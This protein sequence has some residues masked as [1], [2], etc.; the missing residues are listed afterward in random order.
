MT[1]KAT[2]SRLI[3]TVYSIVSPAPESCNRNVPGTLTYDV[4]GWRYNQNT[5]RSLL[6][7][8]LI[9]LA[10]FVLLLTAM[11]L[12][13]KVLYERDPVDLITLLLLLTGGKERGKV[14]VDLE[15]E[16]VYSP[17][18]YSSS[19]DPESERLFAS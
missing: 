9:N 2:Y 16:G 17:P 13:D 15:S 4:I 12:G 1:I 18:W 6:P 8:T 3:E 5:V 14:Q 7:H 11:C 19:A 10:S